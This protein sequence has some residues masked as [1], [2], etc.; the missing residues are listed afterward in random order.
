MEL[1][2]HPDSDDTT[3]YRQPSRT[4]RATVAVFVVI[5]V[6]FA[7]LVILHLAGVVGPGA[8]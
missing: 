2:S 4:S 3:P 1:P 5:G 8:Q 7:V 6:L